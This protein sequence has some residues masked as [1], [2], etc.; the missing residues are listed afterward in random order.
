MSSWTCAKGILV[1]LGP[2]RTAVVRTI[3]DALPEG[4]WRELHDFV[5]RDPTGAVL[6]E[7]RVVTGAEDDDLVAT[8]YAVVDGTFYERVV[9]QH[10]GAVW[11]TDGKERAL[12]AGLRPVAAPSPRYLAEHVLLPR[13]LKERGAAAVLSAMQGGDR[14]YFLPVWMEAGFRFQ[15]R[16]EFGEV[17]GLRLGLMSFPSPR[18]AAEA[19][20]AVVVGKASDPAFLRYFL[21]E[22]G[23][24]GTF[25]TEWKGSSHL[26]HGA[27]AAFTGSLE[28]DGFRFLQ[29]VAEIVGLTPAGRCEDCRHANH[30]TEDVREGLLACPWVGGNRAGRI[31]EIAFEDSGAF[32]FEP[33]TGTNG[34]WGSAGSPFR[35]VPAGYEHRKVIPATG[36]S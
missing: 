15:P 36:P 19:Y 11:R 7:Y 1:D 28:E 34:T 27:G 8:V 21:W 32:C 20:L 16:L 9:I 6:A 31:C 23:E 4:A 35:S 22:R 10:S 2:T 5:L 18:E 3:L 25:I 26:N 33:Y 14:N 29:R 17:N 13:F 24:P 12:L 30:G